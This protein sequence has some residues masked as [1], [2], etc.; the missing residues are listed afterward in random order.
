MVKTYYEAQVDYGG[1]ALFPAELE[2]NVSS[3]KLQLLRIREKDNQGRVGLAVPAWIFYGHIKRAEQI[4][5]GTYYLYDSVGDTSME[6]PA[7]PSN[8]MAINAIDRSVIDLG[9]GY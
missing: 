1:T 2:V 5:G 9:N 7:G 8:G 3:I 6:Y 4:Y